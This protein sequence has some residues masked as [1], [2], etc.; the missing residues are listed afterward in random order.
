VTSDAAPPPLVA[1][2][3]R[4]PRVTA[5]GR[6]R[7][8]AL[9][10]SLWVHRLG[11]VTAPAGA[12]KTTL[13]AQFATTSGVPAAWYRAEAGDGDA[14]TFLGYLGAAIGSALG[15]GEQPWARVED[16][17]GALEA[18]T[19]ERALLVVDDLHLLAGTPA[20]EVLERLIDYAPPG[21][22]VLAGARS[23]PGFNLSRLRV[24]GEL[25]EIG[26]DELRFRSWEVERL[27]HDY[28]G[29]PVPPEVLAELARR[30]E[31]WAAGLQLFHLATRGRRP[32]ERRAVLAAL[33]SRAGLARDYLASNVVAGLPADLREFLQDTCVLGRL[34]G[35]LCDELLGRGGSGELL[36]LLVTAQIFTTRSDPDGWYRYH[37]VLRSH[38]ETALTAHVGEAELRAR[39]RDAGVVLERHGATDDALL[40]YCRAGAW[41][42]VSRL[43]GDRGEDVARGA[44][45]WL[46]LLPAALLRQDLWVLLAQ[47]R[48]DRAAGRWHAAVETYRTIESLADGQSAGT[49]ARAERLAILR[50]M[51]PELRPGQDPLGLL[52]RAVARDPAGTVT[53]LQGQHGADARLVSG[54]GALLAGRVVDATGPL[55]DAAH[56][57]DASPLLAAGARLG[58]AVAALLAGRSRI[59]AVVVSAAEASDGVGAEW[60]TRI[61][62]GALAMVDTAGRSEALAARRTCEAERDA[63]GAAL[64]TLFVALGDV[65]RTGAPAPGEITALGEARA[66]FDAAGAGVLGA[67]AQSLHAIALTAARDPEAGD[68]AVKAEVRSRTLGVPIAELLANIALASLRPER[69]ADHR[70]HAEAIARKCGLDLAGPDA[71]PPAAVEDTPAVADQP[72]AGV[73]CFGGFRILGPGIAD[74]LEGVRPR[75]RTL[76]RLLAMH[77]G[78]PV[79]KEALVAALWPE[80]GEVA[81]TRNLQVAV[82]SLRRALDATPLGIV[83]DGEAYR[84]EVTGGTLDTERFE[85]AVAAA[86]S[87]RAA[88]DVPAQQAALRTLL[89]LHAGEL[90]PEEGPAE[91]V[92]GPR[93]RCAALATEAA[94][95]LAEH[96]LAVDDAGAAIV[97][98][99]RGLQVDRYRDGLWQLLIRAYDLLGNHAASATARKRYAEV[100]ADLG[101]EQ[102]DHLESAG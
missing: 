8:D 9:L 34:S 28:Y 67:W 85:A 39:Y 1:A 16:A 78:R 12:G 98:C 2:R 40:A 4:M 101:V 32:D 49:V 27:F 20:E 10:A 15:I 44:A 63:W 87:A 80:A 29:E 24:A 30:T 99:E 61:A 82:S 93:E 89:D 46:D 58:V 19:G 66:W 54:L 36:E 100:L 7:L 35:P 102:A 18:W 75:A 52:R 48:R 33:H 17:A 6:E 55:L 21:F 5:L 64:L 71:R 37:E 26:T 97:A 74:P 56:A 42:E 47:A 60:L 51:E 59:D 13:L 57:D 95:M 70:R 88:G 96:A 43:V 38:L 53:L 92:L 83:R 81:G 45:D 11:L 86:R 41:Q 84:L 3:I 31:G 73:Q 65:R 50:W 90:L 77:A 69:A 25:L 76:L 94:Q 14:R 79:H 22:V 91:W 62:R 72:T 23:T 68:A